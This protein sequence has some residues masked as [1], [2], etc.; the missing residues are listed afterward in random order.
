MLRTVQVVLICILTFAGCNSQD[1]KE[2]EYNE[3]TNNKKEHDRADTFENTSNHTMNFQNVFFVENLPIVSAQNTF[4]VENSNG[5]RYGL[6]DINGEYILPCEY[7]VISFC[8]TKNDTFLKVMRKG[9]Y[10]VY[11]LDGNEIIP[12]E[13]TEIKCSPYYNCC[14]VGDFY[15]KYG[16]VDFNGNIILPIE[17]DVIDFGYG[18]I[19]LCGNDTNTSGEGIVLAYGLQGQ[20]IKEFRIECGAVNRP[21]NYSIYALSA[22]NGDAVI[23]VH[24]KTGGRKTTTGSHFGEYIYIGNEEL[25]GDT[26]SVGNYL[27]YFENEKLKMTETDIQKECVLWNVP[28]GEGQFEGFA[29]PYLYMS[30]K[31]QHIDYVTGKE[32]VDIEVS[33]APD[34][35]EPYRMALLRV[36]L[37]DEIKTI[38]FHALGIEGTVGNYHDGVALVFP[39]EGYLYSIDTNGKKIAEI[40]QPYTDRSKCFLL[41]NIA[42]AVLCNNDYYIIV[43]DKGNQ[44]LSEEGYSSI[45]ELMTDVCSIT[46]SSGICVLT[47]NNGEAGLVDGFAKEIIPCGVPGRVARPESGT[48]RGNGMDSKK[49]AWEELIILKKE[50]NNQEWWIVFCRTLNGFITEFI[51]LNEETTMIFESILEGNVI[52]NDEMSGLYPIVN[53]GNGGYDIYELK[54]Y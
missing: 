48:S 2:A 15:E 13:Y 53:S 16:V 22:K 26:I 54:L 19:L 3:K 23:N 21:E 47:D 9:S 52:I 17:F 10:G 46:G 32:Y 27:F 50:E 20:L 33:K 51:E 8:E 4:I 28:Q 31:G 36:L 30:I 45:T 37:D 44:L 42:A 1:Y 29:N 7:E 41:K 11:D 39:E 24:W 40:T 43:D 12:C 49:G 5:N 35:Y 6:V 25:V 38:D 14:I 34:M 18:N